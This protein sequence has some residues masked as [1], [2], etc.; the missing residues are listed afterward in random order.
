MAQ[1]NEIENQENAKLI[2]INRMR[3][4]DDAKTTLFGILT[5]KMG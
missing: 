2:K 1:Q 5:L 4:Y 3:N